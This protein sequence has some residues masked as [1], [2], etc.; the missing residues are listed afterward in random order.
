[1]AEFK[2]LLKGE[3]STVALTPWPEVSCGPTLLW[4]TRG[5]NVQTAARDFDGWIASAHYRSHSEIALAASAYHEAGGQQAIVSTIQLDK[6]T[7]LGEL[8]D[9]LLAF[10][11]VG[12]K[13]AAVMFLPGGPDPEQ[14]IQLLE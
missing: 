9:L 5:N 6:N 11:D 3:D 10:A 13:E 2:Q 8:R 1:M 7:D 14:V 4:G 12:F